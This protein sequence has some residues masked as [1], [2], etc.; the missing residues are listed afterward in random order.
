MLKYFGNCNTI[1]WTALV[2]S[3]KTQEPA[4]VGP[5]HKAGD[6]KAIGIDDVANKWINAGYKYKAEGGSASW[7]MFL[8][9]ANFD[10][11]IVFK[12]VDFLGLDNYSNA[13]ISRV[14]PG[15]VAP[16]HWDV[17]DD[18]HTLDS[19]QSVR[20]HCHIQPQVDVIGHT[21][22][23]EDTCL[24]NQA[25]GETY[26]WEARKSWHGAANCGFTPM[27]LFNLWYSK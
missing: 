27:Y 15:Y 21:L 23:V 5:R 26:Q 9:G 1:D 18:E 6:V 16:W 25:I 3:L 19:Q 10:Q 2:E 20:F 22:I 14:N 24:Y 12:F 4:Y 13:W 7:D 8:P 11:S 17:T